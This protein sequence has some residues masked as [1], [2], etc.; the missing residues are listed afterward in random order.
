MEII[1]NSN[2]R[3][4]ER[5]Q[6]EGK[7]ETHP[8]SSPKKVAQA[9][10]SE[11]QT[12]GFPLLNREEKKSEEE[13]GKKEPKTKWRFS[14]SQECMC[15][16]RAPLKSCRISI[17]ALIPLHC[18]AES[19]WHCSRFQLYLSNAQWSSCTP[20]SISLARPQAVGLQHVTPAIRT[21][22]QQ[23]GEGSQ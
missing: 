3:K 22:G 4:W 13:K 17:Q 20:E 2:N 5:I 9:A 7:E 1:G 14:S 19:Q 15:Y 12:T 21:G 11:M 10:I 8:F 23:K 6:A 16:A 18:F